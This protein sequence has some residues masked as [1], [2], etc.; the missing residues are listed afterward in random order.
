MDCHPLLLLVVFIIDLVEHDESVTKG[1]KLSYCVL[2][3]NTCRY[4]SFV[5]TT[6][7]MYIHVAIFAKKILFIYASIYGTLNMDNLIINKLHCMY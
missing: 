7:H 4:S 1:G 6:T 5:D 2:Y 3:G